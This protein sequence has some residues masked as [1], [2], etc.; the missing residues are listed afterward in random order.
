MFK[1]YWQKTIFRRG[2]ASL[3]I[4]NYTGS[5]HFTKAYRL[6][7]AYFIWIG[8]YGYELKLSVPAPVKIRNE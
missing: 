5:K 2:V 4:G 7:G 8:L 6:I 3:I 1:R